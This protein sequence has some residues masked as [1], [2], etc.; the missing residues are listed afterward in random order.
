MLC[1]H[2]YPKTATRVATTSHKQKNHRRV[3]TEGGL[4]PLGSIS[5]LLRVLPTHLRNYAATTG[6]DGE[7]AVLIH[8]DTS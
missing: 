2:H 1:L 8:F 5:S 3:V 4:N 6:A 7:F